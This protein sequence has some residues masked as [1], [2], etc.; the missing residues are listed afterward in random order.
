MND[1]L[2]NQVSVLMP[3]FNA[4]LYLKEAIES[5]LNQTYAHFEFIIINDGST[6]DS[7]AIIQ[8]YTDPRIVLVNNALNMGIIAS[9]NKGLS[10]A[11]GK[12]IANMDADDIS[13]SDRLEKQ[14]S[15]L[16]LH[17][18]IAILA[19]RLVLIDTKNEEIGIWPEDHH[20]IYEKQIYDHL[21]LANCI[22]QLTIMM[23]TEVIKKFGYNPAF[24]YNEDWG[25]W[26]TVL[27]HNYR[28]AKL[29]ETLLRYRQ[30]PKSTT[31]TANSFGVEKKTLAFKRR[32][33]TFKFFNGGIIN[34]DKKVLSS[35]FKDLLRF[36]FKKLSPKLYGFIVRL[37]GLDKPRFIKQWFQL[38]GL[39][40]KVSKPVNAV[41]FFPF[42]HTGGAERVHASILESAGHK[43]A[44]TFISSRSS[45]SA[46]LTK[47]SEYSPVIEIDELVKLGITRRLLF[48]KIKQL[49]VPVIFGC[50][51]AFFY[52]LIPHLD[53][54]TKVI[55]LLHAFV[56]VHED[57]PEKWS[58][59]Y[60]TRITNRVVINQKTKND[61]SALYAKHHISTALTE[62][63]KLIPNFV[64][65]INSL[66]PKSDTVLKIA[67]VGR[68]GEEKRVNLIARLAANFANEKDTFE[69]HFV[70]DVKQVISEVYQSA[71]IFHNEVV[72]DAELETLYDRFHVLIIASTREGFPMVMMEAMM[73]GV[74]PLSTNV[75]GIPEHIKDGENGLLVESLDEQKI[76]NDFENKIRYLALNR[77][78]LKRMSE[79]AHNYALAHFS[80]AYFFK[81][82]KELLSS[83]Y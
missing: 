12:Y 80:K 13:A 65:T 17:P 45:N 49:K 22:G 52:D 54:N 8:S 27:S 44:I 69:F 63:I 3:V 67:Y 64:E 4:S 82:Y 7:L 25:L 60:V 61:L 21:P 56:H 18:D 35:Y 11:R 75:G 26:L 20:C 38:N 48:K 31:I 50:N 5:I 55:D 40:N 57:G 62:R 10:I 41:Y 30:H 43:N 66:T 71:C 23:R 19:A 47:F 78:E 83:E 51:S 2:N 53:Q 33:L 34:S 70:G 24:L 76:L 9:R 28:I 29:P 36:V 1:S 68:G 37:K 39:L 72:N 42:Y 59:P 32:Y 73:H 15:Y 74:V 16:D 46:F 77:N 6:D 58:L 79:N 14:V 81:S